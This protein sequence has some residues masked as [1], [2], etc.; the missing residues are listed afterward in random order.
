MNV[1][2]VVNLPDEI[3][4]GIGGLLSGKDVEVVVRGV[5]SGVPLCADSGSEQD[6]ISEQSGQSDGL[7]GPHGRIAEAA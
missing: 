1:S 2:W 3:T 6:E 7:E 5:S 4:S